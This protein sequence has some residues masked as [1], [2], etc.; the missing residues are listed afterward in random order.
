[1]VA[2][3]RA[4]VG[5]GLSLMAAFCTL[6]HP[7]ACPDMSCILVLT[8]PTSLPQH[9]L[10]PPGCWGCACESLLEISAGGMWR[11]AVPGLLFTWGQAMV[12]VAQPAQPG[13]M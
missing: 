13:R 12:V 1:M 3:V 11:S 9:V 10:Y 5:L 2:T 4:T 6:I 8:H 7:A